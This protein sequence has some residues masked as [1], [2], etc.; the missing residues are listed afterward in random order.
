MNMSRLHAVFFMFL[1]FF[2]LSGETNDENQT[3][4]EEFD[5]VPLTSQWIVWGGWNISAYDT[6]VEWVPKGQ[7]GAVIHSTSWW[8]ATALL[9]GR[10]SFGQAGTS[11]K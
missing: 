2:A 9:C 8:W 5:A 4:R 10:H 1:M 7:G 3:K 11:P 6:S